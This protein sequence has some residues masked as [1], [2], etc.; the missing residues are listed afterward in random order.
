MALY[1]SSRRNSSR[2]IPFQVP[3]SLDP[4]ACRR[5]RA[6][7]QDLR[8]LVNTALGQSEETPV[9]LF[10]GRPCFALIGPEAFGLRQ[11]FPRSPDDDTA[12]RAAFTFWIGCRLCH[13]ACRCREDDRDT[14]P[15]HRYPDGAAPRISDTLKEMGHS[16]KGNTILIPHSPG[17]LGDLAGQ[18]RLARIT[19]DEVKAQS[20]G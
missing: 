6:A 1:G 12:H 5:T 19:A 14:P 13:R 18:V 16:S 10:T 3:G 9:T 11:P 20:T 8:L 4:P 7:A 17:H 2:R 15:R